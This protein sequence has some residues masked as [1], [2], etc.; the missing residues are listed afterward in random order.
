MESS[1]LYINAILATKMY[2]D[3]FF[4]NMKYVY[5]GLKIMINRTGAGLTTAALG[6]N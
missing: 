3:V 6:Q 1:I 4:W 5:Y 2:C